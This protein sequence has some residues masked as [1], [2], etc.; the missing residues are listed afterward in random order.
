MI[1]QRPQA[2]LFLAHAIESIV[3]PALFVVF[4]FGVLALDGDGRRR[5]RSRSDDAAAAAS[6]STD[7]VWRRF[8][9]AGQQRSLQAAQRHPGSSH[10]VHGQHVTVEL[11]RFH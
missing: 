1:G 3:S 2:H 11:R 9:Q 8:V 5:R 10:S 4:R 7:A 6:R